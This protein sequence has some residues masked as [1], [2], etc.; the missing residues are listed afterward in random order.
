MWFTVLEAEK[1]K[2]MMLMSSCGITTWCHMKRPS[3]CASLDLSLFL[4]SH[5]IKSPPCSYQMLIPIQWPCLQVSLTAE[6]DDQGS[7]MVH[8]QP[9]Q[10]G[11][12]SV[13]TLKPQQWP[14]CPVVPVPMMWPIALAIIWPHGTS[15]PSIMKRRSFH[16]SVIQFLWPFISI[17]SLLG[18]C[19]PVCF[20]SWN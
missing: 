7:N 2:E 10:H 16:D 11:T 19:C 5:G 17:L 8:S 12:L 6:F 3:K 18:L 4:D 20:C 14:S 9:F 1:P 15:C 13:D